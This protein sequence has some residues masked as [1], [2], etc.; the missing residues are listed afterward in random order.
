VHILCGSDSEF[1]LVQQ[2][3][4]PA[5]HLHMWNV[6]LRTSPDQE[7]ATLQ[8]IC[9][10]PWDRPVLQVRVFPQG[11]T[12][13]GG[14]STLSSL[15]ALLQG[16]PE[17]YAVFVQPQEGAT[18][19]QVYSAVRTC[20]TNAV[21]FGLVEEATPSDISSNTRALASGQS[22]PCAFDA[23]VIRVAPCKAPLR[24][25]VIDDDPRW[26]VELEVL[27]HEMKIP[28]PPGRQECYVADAQAVFGEK[29]E[30]V[31]GAYRFSYTWN[32]DVPGKPQFENFRAASG[33]ATSR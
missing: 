8:G 9:A 1:M 6:C 22:I 31:S 28:F 27:P 33:V 12:V 3:I 21:E 13:N 14:D 17:K 11:V 19:G 15:D 25:Y 30:G 26:I 29:P 2:V 10:G 4:D 24:G 18:A 32:I 7:P 23:E 5:T 16:D 20:E